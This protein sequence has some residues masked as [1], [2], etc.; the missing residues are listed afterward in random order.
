MKEVAFIKQ[1]KSKWLEFVQLLASDHPQNRMRW[2]AF[3]SIC[4]T[5]YLLPRPIIQKAGRPITSIFWFHKY[6]VKFIKRNASKG[7]GCGN[8]L[9]T[10]VSLLM[11]KYR[12]TMWFAFVMFLFFTI[13][14]AVSAKY[15]DTF[16]RLILGDEYVNMT[17]ENIEKG[18][19][20]AVYKSGGR[21]GSFIGITVNNIYVALR[22]FIFGVAGG[23]PYFLILPCRTGS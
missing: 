19:P 20:M 5:T 8:S 23:C 22:A 14:G 9:K 3:I 12:K 21:M 15:D 1:N 16:V 11:H 18:D 10:D 17:L 13:L 6:T 7:T 4:S 2:L